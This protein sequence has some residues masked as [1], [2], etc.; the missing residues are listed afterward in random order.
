[1]M[2]HNVS[3]VTRFIKNV[4]DHESLLQNVMVRGEISN[5]KRYP[6]GHCY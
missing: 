6:S 3:D 1:M 5:F 4:L 2:I